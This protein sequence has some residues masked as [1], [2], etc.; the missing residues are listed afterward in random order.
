MFKVGIV[1]FSRNKTTITTIVILMV[2][3]LHHHGTIPLLHHHAQ[4]PILTL[5]RQVSCAKGPA[6]T[7]SGGGA[8]ME[9]VRFFEL[10]IGTG[11][12]DPRI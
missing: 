10:V 1:I 5:S 12:K 11:L 4:D 2:I 6:A 7:H 9:G 8:T 3:L